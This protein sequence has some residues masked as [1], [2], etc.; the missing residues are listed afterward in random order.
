MALWTQFTQAQLLPPQSQPQ[1]PLMPFQLPTTQLGFQGS[2][3]Q[4]NNKGLF[5]RQGDVWC[6]VHK[7]NST[8][9]TEQWLNKWRKKILVRFISF[10]ATFFPYIFS[11]EPL[12]GAKAELTISL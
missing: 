3:G 9:E 6:Q 8:H 12:L 10:V 2:Q 11:L 7:W 5:K 4:K 1:V